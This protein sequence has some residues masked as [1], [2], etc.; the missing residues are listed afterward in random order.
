MLAETVEASSNG[1]ASV[2]TVVVLRKLDG[3]TSIVVIH[4]VQTI[5]THVPVGST[6]LPPSLTEYRIVEGVGRLVNA[7]A[8]FKTHPHVR[9]YHTVVSLIPKSTS[10]KKCTDD[11]LIC[12]GRV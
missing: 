7:P 5:R 6:L 1:F 11:T 8:S 2:G 3:N 10:G 12:P 9:I 4:V